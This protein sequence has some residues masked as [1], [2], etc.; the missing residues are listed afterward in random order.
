MV[1]Y[2][3]NEQVLAYME[4]ISDK[5]PEGG[6]SS[7]NFEMMITDEFT[8]AVEIS[9]DNSTCESKP[10]MVAN[11]VL[12]FYRPYPTTT[13]MTVFRDRYLDLQ[14]EKNFAAGLTQLAN[15]VANKKSTAFVYRFDYRPKTQPVAKDVPEWAGVP[16]MFELPFVW[17]LP[18]MMSVGATQWNFNDK[19][20]SES[21][22]TMPRSMRFTWVD[23]DSTI[24]TSGKL[25]NNSGVTYCG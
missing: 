4:V 14:T 25:D 5:N 15:K 16:H 8:A 10:E 6:L 20:M 11:A 24:I 19:R 22:M 17:G 12:F 9:D 2:T 21:M 1:G 3:N 18:H 7:E 23:V 13:N